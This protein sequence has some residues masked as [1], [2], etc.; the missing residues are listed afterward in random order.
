MR[1]RAIL[2]LIIIFNT[3]LLRAQVLFDDFKKGTL[4][5]AIWLVADTKWG[6]N[7]EK[8]T[9][10]GV[11]PENIIVKDGNLIIRANGDLYKGSIKGHGQ[12]IRVGGAISTKALFASGSF[13]IRAKICPQPGALSAFWTFYYENEDYNHEIDFEFPGHNQA[14]NGPDSS[15]MDWGLMTNW[16]GVKEGQ[17]KNADK[18]FGNQTDGEYHL[19]RFEW[20]TG[21]AGEKP[22][23]EWYYDNKLM[24]TSFE[25]VPTHAGSYYIG[26]WFPWWIKEANF[27][28]D[29]MYVDWVKITP[30]KE[31]NDLNNISKPK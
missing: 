20:H 11:V 25:K 22:R 18:Y 4:D 10:G 9:H 21:N 16:T 14:P 6:E 1:M 17:Y 8:R 2:L 12:N 30:F 5:T 31:S 15:R 27:D 28:T 13:E 7:A 24:H 26:I 19:Y 29:Y 23:V 3:G